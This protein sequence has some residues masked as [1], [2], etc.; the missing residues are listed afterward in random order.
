MGQLAYH[1]TEYLLYMLAERGSSRHTVRAFQNDLNEFSKYLVGQKVLHPKDVTTDIIV[2]FLEHQRQLGNCATTVNRRKTC[3]KSYM[4]FLKRERVI[5]TDFSKFFAACRSPS[6]HRKLPQILTE[7]EMKKL[8]EFPFRPTFRGVRNKAILEILYATGIRACELCNL[9]LDD[10]RDGC[11]R[12]FGKNSK[13]RLVPMHKTAKNALHT[14]LLY[15]V[16]E[17]LLTEK[18]ALFLNKQGKRMHPLH[19]YTLVKSLVKKAGIK[20][21]VSPHV[22]RHTYATHMLENGCNVRVLQE[23]LGH[24]SIMTTQ[25]YL[26][27]STKFISKSF[28]Q[29]HPREKG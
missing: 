28:H 27:L 10:V 12:I 25:L 15:P 20:K 29:C 9:N 22:I 4:R 7:R 6:S 23:L 18:K 19:L 21:K 24:R 3:L 26:H 16:D 13:E 1:V 8:I 2:G 5:S 14:Y 11:L 17:A